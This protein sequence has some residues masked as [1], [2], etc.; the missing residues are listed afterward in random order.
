MC[1]FHGGK[2][3]NSIIISLASSLIA[4][5]LSESVVSNSKIDYHRVYTV[6]SMTLIISYLGWSNK[7]SN[8]ND[9]SL[10]LTLWLVCFQ[11]TLSILNK[12]RNK[13]LN[14]LIAALA[15][16][17]G[18][19]STINYKMFIIPFFV[20]ALIKLFMQ[21]RT[22]QNKA[23]ILERIFEPYSLASLL[24][25]I[26]NTGNNPIPALIIVLFMNLL[27]K[28]LTNKIINP[29]TFLFETF[30]IWASYGIT[31]I[32]IIDQLTN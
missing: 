10:F 14:Y 9:I 19:T 8:I 6:A 28:Y 13:W 31:F 27:V 32:V 26:L 30:Q 7:I 16:T 15:I 25:I 20:F 12:H 11:A 23:A 24:L 4:V 21:A 1:Y 22:D 29:K 2:V 5:I 3:L 18:L 17:Y